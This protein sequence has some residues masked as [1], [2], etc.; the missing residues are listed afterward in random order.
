[1]TELKRQLEQSGKVA[2]SNTNS[3]FVKQQLQLTE[4]SVLNLQDQLKKAQEEN[5][6]LKSNHQ[7]K[8][9]TLTV[10]F[11]RKIAQ[12]EASILD[13]NMRV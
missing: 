7:N 4:Q 6:S 1:M 3:E 9:M 5:N 8:E 10:E 11:N 13:S 12:L 2:A